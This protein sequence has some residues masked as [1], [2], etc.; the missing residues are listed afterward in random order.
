MDSEPNRWPAPGELDESV[1]PAC[2]RPL[3]WWQEECPVCREPATLRLS[4]PTPVLPAVPAHLRD[5]IDEDAVSGSAANAEGVPD[6]TAEL[7]AHKPQI[8]PFDADGP[9]PV[10][11]LTHLVPGGLAGGAGGGGGAGCGDGGC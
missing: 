5:A 10:P 11:T 2:H 6:G 7:G 1:C 9:S 8:A 4:V 3:P